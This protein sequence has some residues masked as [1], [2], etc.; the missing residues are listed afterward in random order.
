MKIWQFTIRLTGT[1]LAYGS[2]S[3]HQ[4]NTYWMKGQQAKRQV[5]WVNPVTRPVDP[6]HRAVLKVWTYTLDKW[7]HFEIYL[8]PHHSWGPFFSDFWSGASFERNNFLNVFIFWVSSLRSPNLGLRQ[9]MS[10][11]VYNK[12]TKIPRYYMDQ[13]LW[14]KRWHNKS[15]KMAK[16]D[17]GCSFF[18]SFEISCH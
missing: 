9:N 15:P 13:L 10:S 8:S 16:T 12:W 17:L 1:E 14:G 4:L 18:L 3:Y 11:A 7:L 6:G 5:S 2:G